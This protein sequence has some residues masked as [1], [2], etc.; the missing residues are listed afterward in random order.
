MANP[1]NDDLVQRGANWSMRKAVPLEY[2]AVEPKKEITR[3][4]RTDSRSEAKRRKEAVWDELVAGWEMR[5]AGKSDDAHTAFEAAKRVLKAKELRYIPLDELLFAPTAEILARVSKINLV[6]GRPD[7]AEASAI[8]GTEE[9]PSIMLADA[10]E[11]YWPMAKDNTRGKSAD[12]MRRWVNP[13]KKAMRNF[14]MVVGDKCPS[15]GFLEPKA[16]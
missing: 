16:A 7:A 5:L 14:I 3:S 10:L 9:R 1:Q 8:L 12:Q 2:R 11:L 6:G 15:S 4:L 13:R